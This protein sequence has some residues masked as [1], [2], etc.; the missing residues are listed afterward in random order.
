MSYYRG[1]LVRLLYDHDY[2]STTDFDTSWSV[3]D[4]I[5]YDS[6]SDDGI[7]WQNITQVMCYVPQ[8]EISQ[9]SPATR[10]VMRYFDPESHVVTWSADVKNL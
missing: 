9:F 3:M 10:K 1:P 8:Q 7:L 2:C 5:D 4:V 6:D